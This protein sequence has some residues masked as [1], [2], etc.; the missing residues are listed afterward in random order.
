MQEHMSFAIAIRGKHVALVVVAVLSGLSCLPFLR[1]IIML[2]DEGVLLQGADRLLRGEK[3]YRDFF[4]FLPPGG[5]LLTAGWFGLTNVSL[6]SARLLAAF[7]FVGIACVLYCVAL[8]VSRSTLASA[9]AVAAFVVMSQGAWMQV[10][11]HWFTTLFC[12]SALFGAL[13]WIHTRRLSWVFFAGLAGGAAAMITPTRGSLAVIAGLLA[14]T[15]GKRFDVAAL[16]NYIAAAAI[17]PTLCIAYVAFQGGLGPAFN[18]VIVYP[19]LHYANIQSVPYGFAADAQNMP[20]NFIFPVAALL[21]MVHFA[22]DWPAAIR[23]RTLHVCVAFALAAFVGLLVRPD[24]VHITF[25]VPLVLPLILY[26]GRRFVAVFRPIRVVTI[27]ALVLA[28]ALSTAVLLIKSYLVM[29]LPNIETPRGRVKVLREDVRLIIRRVADLPMESTVFYYPYHP[30]LAFLTARGHPSRSDIFIP[31]YTTANQF[32]EECRAVIHSADWVVFDHAMINNWQLY[33]PAIRDPAPPERILF[34]SAI[35]RSFSLVANEGKFD[36]RKAFKRD[37]TICNDI[38][39][40][41]EKNP[42]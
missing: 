11:H 10:S 41:R 2:G 22:R 8:R 33:F 1:S 23:D 27:A 21:A 42:T 7:T 40:R 5:F 25:A 28:M 4:Q 30:L 19:A 38:S 16:T 29:Q 20:L 17:L 3:L 15:E 13:M 14:L 39:G 9:V 6:F 32:E 37:E 34:E 36:L 18:C 26:S 24:I 12:I 31:N 35:E